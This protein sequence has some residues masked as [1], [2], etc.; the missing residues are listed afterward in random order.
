[1]SFSRWLRPHIWRCDASPSHAPPFPL[2]PGRL[3]DIDARPAKEPSPAAAGDATATNGNTPAGLDAPEAVLLDAHSRDVIAVVDR[4]GPAVVRLDARRNDNRADGSG[5]IVSPHGLIL[6][7]H[8]V[9]G[10][11]ST[12]KVTTAEGWSLVA[13]IV[14]AD[15]DTDLALIRVKESVVL[16]SA[17]LGDSNG[18]RRRQLVIAIGASRDSCRRHDPRH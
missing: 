3:V 9:V 15:P 10:A 8:H 14:G 1:M 18:L 2:R 7:S 16:P 13:R 4:T 17:Q 12:V 11:G 6:T 5:V